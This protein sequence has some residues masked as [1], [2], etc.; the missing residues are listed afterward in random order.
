MKMKQ[1]VGM[2]FI[3]SFCLFGE[4]REVTP[5]SE[6]SSNIL[7]E[8][9]QKTSKIEKNIP[10][11][12]EEQ[13]NTSTILQSLGHSRNI[14]QKDSSQFVDISE[15]DNRN[16]IIY[17]QGEDTAFTGVFALF[18][19]DWIQYI[20]TYKNGKLDGESSWYTQNGTQVLLEQYQAGKLHGS[21]LSYYENGSPK[22]EV[23]YDRGRI[24]GVI[25][26]AKNGDIIHKSI[27]NNGTGIWKLYWENGKLL[28]TGKYTN[29]RKDGIWKKYNEDGSL[30]STLEYRNGKLL[31]ETWG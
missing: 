22:A 31:K 5:L 9:V 28:E 19:G 25:C 11:F 2:F 26:F 17:R 15:Q 29:F 6:L 7:G 8:K 21:Q 13:K 24:T 20:E 1:Y 4:I 27:F 16:G 30:E 23:I 10:K 14:S 3:L 12:S 18:M